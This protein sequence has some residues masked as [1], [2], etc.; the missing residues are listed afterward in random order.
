MDNEV[1]PVDIETFGSNVLFSSYNAVKSDLSYESF[2]NKNLQP[3]YAIPGF[4]EEL[5]ELI[6]I[7]KQRP[8]VYA[9]TGTEAELKQIKVVNEYLSLIPPF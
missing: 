8:V 4:L 7:A 6:Q 9:T 3:D 1:T 5:D 2:F